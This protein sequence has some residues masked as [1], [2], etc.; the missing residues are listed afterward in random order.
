M[1]NLFGRNFEATTTKFCTHVDEHGFQR[2]IDFHDHRL[3]FSYILKIIKLNLRLNTVFTN[4]TKIFMVTFV[5]K[6][7]VQPNERKSD[8]LIDQIHH[9]LNIA[10]GNEQHFNLF[11]TVSINMCQIKKGLSPQKQIFM[12]EKKFPSLPLTD[13]Y[14]EKKQITPDRKHKYL[15][16]FSNRCFP[17]T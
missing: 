5:T 3:M 6:T 4:L 10:C 9:N 7:H 13:I 15:P 8:E 14:V 16:I 2:C 12:T 1:V 11:I 17:T